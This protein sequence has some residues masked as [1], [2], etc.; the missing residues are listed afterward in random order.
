MAQWTE[1]S[2][3]QGTKS[4][5]KIRVNVS[6]VASIKMAGLVC[7]R[8][9]KKRDKKIVGIRYGSFCIWWPGTKIFWSKM[10]YKLKMSSVMP[11]TF[12]VV[13]LR[14]DRFNTGRLICHGGTSHL[15]WW[16]R[17]NFFWPDAKTSWT[18]KN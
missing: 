1:S 5:N 3:M 9:W 11:F 2:K 6:C 7:V 8:R 14:V 4:L 18:K 17:I 10:K 15:W 16:G 12:N 13:E